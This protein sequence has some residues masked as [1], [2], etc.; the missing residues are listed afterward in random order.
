MSDLNPFWLEAIDLTDIFGEIDLTWTM[1]EFDLIDMSDLFDMGDMGDLLSDFDL[2]SIDELFPPDPEM[3]KWLDD[4][5]NGCGIGNLS[6][7]FP[8][9]GDAEKFATLKTLDR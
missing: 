8:D 6:F 2:I 5:T 4:L 7:D 1:P 9:W 3:N